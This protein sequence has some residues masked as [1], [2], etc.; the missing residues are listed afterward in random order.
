[1]AYEEKFSQRKTYETS[2][3]AKN[4]AMLMY[5]IL[6]IQ[7][8]LMYYILQSQY[9]EINLNIVIHRLILL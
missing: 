4:T 9:K 8:M 3:Y 6:K 7:Q 2:V 5:Q 1:M